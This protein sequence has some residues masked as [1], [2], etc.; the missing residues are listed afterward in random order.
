MSNPSL[1]IYWD[2]AD[3]DSKKIYKFLHVKNSQFIEELK[4]GR[5]V[6]LHKRHDIF[7]AS[8]GLYQDIDAC[9]VLLFFTHGENDAILKRRYGDNDAKTR[10]SLIDLNNVEILSGK[11]VVSICCS[12]AKTLGLESIRRGCRVF[13]GFEKDIIYS[14]GKKGLNPIVYSAYND[15]FEQA[16]KDAVERNLTASEFVKSLR[17]ALTKNITAKVLNAPGPAPYSLS[18]QIAYLDGINSIVALGESNEPL[19]A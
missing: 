1:F 13:V 6:C 5:E 12:S 2:Y 11:K 9:Q 19:F 8:D 16:I 7:D 15:A 14:T 10:F 17:L 18:E 3:N 4:A